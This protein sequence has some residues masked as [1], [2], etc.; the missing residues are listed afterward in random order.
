[1]RLLWFAIRNIGRNK[2]R[3]GT[4]LGMIALG[5]IA[6]L[7]AG[8]YAAATFHNLR[9]NTIA[10]GIGHLQ[11][12]GPGF[13][14]Q[15]LEEKPLAS[16]LRNVEAV[17]RL[18]KADPRVRAAV[19]RVD[20]NG[21]ISNGEKSQIFIGSGV[22]PHEEYGAA[23]FTPTIQSGRPVA[24]GS[25]HEVVL[26]IGLARSMGAHL[27]DRLTLLG[28]TVDGAINGLDVAVVGTYTTGIKEFDDRAAV[29]RIDTA[30]QILN[31]KDVSKLVVLLRD[32]E[33]TDAVHDSLTASLQ[34]AGQHVEI[35]S[36]VQ[37]ATFYR[38]VRALFSGIFAFLGLII[39][40][41]VV[42][43]SGNAMSM[44]VLERVREI[45]TLMAV[46]TTRRTVMAMFVAEGV[47]LG[48]LGA[49]VGVALGSVLATLLTR[50]QIQLPPPPTFSR[51][52]PLTILVERPLLIAVPILLIFTLFLASLLPA[53]RAAR[54]RI[55]DALGHL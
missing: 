13:L 26:G 43:S 36:W 12:G 17:R 1:M 7:L 40:G 25:S 31:T 18:A 52:V 16:G 19:A 49:A 38:Q 44:A 10:N 8:G 50:A 24:D 37:F 3:S 5:A 22:E 32:T 41:L 29:V 20:F 33:E 48:T 46:G 47:A 15:E 51:P 11:M 55:T 2:R 14:A 42:L 45:G 23:G 35:A 34:A 9:E 39:L 53:A 4:I 6:L 28:Q 27:G 21:L 30:Q 54:L